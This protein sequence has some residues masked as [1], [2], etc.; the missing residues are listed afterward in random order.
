MSPSRDQIVL[1]YN[2][3]LK[4]QPESEE[5]IQSWL[6]RDLSLDDIVHAMTH[7]DEFKTRAWHDHLAL[8]RAE[9]KVTRL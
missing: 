9:L 8:V 5:A 1:L 6:V 2:K 4:R 3:I 7:S